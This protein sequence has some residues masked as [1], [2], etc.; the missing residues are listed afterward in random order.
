[1]LLFL[2]QRKERSLLLR[3][4]AENLRGLL[5]SQGSYATIVRSRATMPETVV[6]LEEDLEG[7]GFMHLLLIPRKNLQTKGKRNPPM[8]KK[9]DQSTI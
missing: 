4:K 3:R 9:K 5:I 6:N 8:N 1:M 7:R 2:K